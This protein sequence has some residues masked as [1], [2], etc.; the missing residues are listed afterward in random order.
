VL[1][2]CIQ[3]HIVTEASSTAQGPIVS[4]CPDAHPG[5]AAD[6]TLRPEQV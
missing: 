5:W 6:W 1:A 3:E 2:A 4:V